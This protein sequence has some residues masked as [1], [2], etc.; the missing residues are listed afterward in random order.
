MNRKLAVSLSKLFLMIMFLAL[1]PLPLTG[2]T[3]H[4]ASVT[5]TIEDHD[6]IQDGPRCALCDCCSSLYCTGWH[7]SRCS[8]GGCWLHPSFKCTN[9]PDA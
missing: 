2:T 6:D 9:Y 1:G 5:A 3:A 7:W 4:A 8:I